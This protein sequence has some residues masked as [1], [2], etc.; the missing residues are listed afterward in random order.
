MPDSLAAAS[1]GLA[2]A[3]NRK[4]RD[5]IRLRSGFIG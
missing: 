5:E 3:A 4:D 1:V 2:L